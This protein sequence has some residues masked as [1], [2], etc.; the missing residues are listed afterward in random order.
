MS[1]RKHESGGGQRICVG[2]E[3]PAM[4][5]DHFE[6]SGLLAA[7]ADSVFA[8]ADDPARLSSHMSKSSWMMAVAGCKP[9]SMRVVVKQSARAF[10]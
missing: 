1:L 4:F 8:Y 7:P 6:A 3:P 5:S 2:V 10:A 9:S